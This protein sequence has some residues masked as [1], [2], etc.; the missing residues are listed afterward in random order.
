MEIQDLWHTVGVSIR[1]PKV[2]VCV[3]SPEENPL[4]VLEA[5]LSSRVGCLMLQP[6]GTGWGTVLASGRPCGTDLH[7]CLC[8]LSCCLNARLPLAWCPNLLFLQP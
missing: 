5:I 4:K 1:I 3:K 7:P 2:K 6:L 8:S